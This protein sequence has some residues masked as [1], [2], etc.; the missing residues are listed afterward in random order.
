MPVAMAVVGPASAQ[1]VQPNI[2]QGHRA[3]P[4]Y[5]ISNYESQPHPFPGVHGIRLRVACRTAFSQYARYLK[6]PGGPAGAAAY[7]SFVD[8]AQGVIRYHAENRFGSTPIPGPAQSGAPASTAQATARVEEI[9]KKSL[10]RG[11]QKHHDLPLR[12]SE[13]DAREV[14][15]YVFGAVP[16]RLDENDRRFAQALILE[17]AQT[18]AKMSYVESLFR[19]ATRPT[20]TPSSVLRAIWRTLLRDLAAPDTVQQALDSEHYLIVVQQVG[21]NWSRAWDTR[22]QDG[23]SDML[24][25]L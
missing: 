9:Q 23:D 25:K 10:G 11:L 22:M 21:L 20:A 7:G 16:E 3:C 19:S 4:G 1:A 5:T 2:L 18:S 13:A 15:I 24:L 6:S 17:T 14:L 8:S 12:L